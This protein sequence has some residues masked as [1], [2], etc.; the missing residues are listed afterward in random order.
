M[1]GHPGH[2]QPMGQDA[3]G[4]SWSLCGRCG[5][6]PMPHPARLLSQPCRRPA[7]SCSAHP[8]PR[9]D[10]GNVHESVVFLQRF[11]LVENLHLDE[12]TE[13][14]ETPVRFKA[15]AIWQG[16]SKLGVGGGTLGRKD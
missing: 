7:P 5:H 15:P 6:R 3:N 13:D 16:G 12:E 2:A 14:T 9:I 1:A 10:V 11:I 4:D 8:P